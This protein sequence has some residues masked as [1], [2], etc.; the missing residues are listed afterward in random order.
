MLKADVISHAHA[1][2][3]LQISGPPEFRDSVIAEK[4]AEFSVFR[5]IHYFPWN[6]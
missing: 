4:N 3:Y 5:G 2:V 1:G 6:L